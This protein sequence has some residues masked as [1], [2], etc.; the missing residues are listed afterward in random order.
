M[1]E[2]A[3]AKADKAPQAIPLI[4]TFKKH[5]KEVLITTCAKFVE[6]GPFYIFATF[7]VGYATS[8]LDISFTFM[9]LAVMAAALITTFMIPLM[10]RLSDTYGRRPLFLVGSGAML[11]YA[12]PYFLLVDTHNP[13]LIILATII[14]LSII[15]PPITAVLGTMFSEAFSR[16]VRYTGVTLGYQFG[17]ALAGGT[18]P[19]IAEF[20]MES[21]GGSSI[22]VSLYIIFTAVV[23]ITA[24]WFLR[25]ETAQDR[26]DKAYGF[27]TENEANQLDIKDKEY[28][29]DTMV[30]E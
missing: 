11:L 19:L 2:E 13:M 12:F 26:E 18:A 1:K 24:V 5:P 30:K 15:W 21:F 8:V 3:V 6:T 4:E 17:A 16:E 10:G 27:D 22:P 25:G 28:G 20:L 23:S 29:F 9:M 7:I 14:G